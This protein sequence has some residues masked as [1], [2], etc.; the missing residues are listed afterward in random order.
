MSKNCD[1]YDE[2]V[3]RMADFYGIDLD[4]KNAGDDEKE[5]E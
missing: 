2:A 5:E 3:K 1:A 4:G